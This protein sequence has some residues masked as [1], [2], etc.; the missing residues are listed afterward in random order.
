MRHRRGWNSKGMDTVVA[1][2]LM[3]VIVVAASV[4]IYS[5]SLGVFGAALPAPPNGREILTMEN[6]GFDATNMNMTLYLR[7]TG[8]APTTL[9]SYY[10]SDLNGDQYAKTSWTV[11]TI[12]PAALGKFFI[13]INTACSCSRTGSAFTFQPGNTYTVTLATARNNQFTFTIL[14]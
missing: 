2:L 11:Q 6:Q 13:L 10:V 5:W 8:T 12:S 4:M 7:N 3:V 1:A 14:R 9:V